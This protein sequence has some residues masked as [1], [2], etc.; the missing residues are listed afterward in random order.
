MSESL[1]LDPRIGV[2]NSGKYYAF[3]NGY[4][5]PETVGT[6]E[7]VQRALET[8]EHRNKARPDQLWNVVLRFQYPAWDEVDGITYRDIQAKSKSEAIAYARKM[9]SNDG[10]TIGGGKGRYWFTAISVKNHIDQQLMCE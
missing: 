1:R 2:L 6:L 9:A 5:H 3:V 7:H 8:T 4:D 10:H